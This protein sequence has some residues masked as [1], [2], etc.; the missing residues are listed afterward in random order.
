MGLIRAPDVAGRAEF[1]WQ[2]LTDVAVD[3]YSCMS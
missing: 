2:V 3:K 1:R